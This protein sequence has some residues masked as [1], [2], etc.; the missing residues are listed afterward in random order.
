MESIRTLLESPLLALLV[1]VIGIIAGWVFYVRTLRDAN[2]CYQTRS[3][4][5]IGSDSVT[6]DITIS[7]KGVVVPHV[8]KS[9]LVFWNAGRGTL[10]GSEIVRDDP[11]RVQSN[12]QILDARVIKTTRDINAFKVQDV[13]SNTDVLACTLEF[14]DHRDGVT[15]SLFHTGTG[16]IKMLG[17]IQ[18]IRKGVRNKG[19]ISDISVT[20]LIKLIRVWFILFII[21]TLVVAYYIVTQGWHPS[22]LV[23]QGVMS[24][25]FVFV[26]MTIFVVRRVLA[27][28]TDAP[29]K[30][31]VLDGA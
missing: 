21:T 19:S 3:F 9:I 23:S 10:K 2:P 8:T 11:L 25:G 27:F 5:V 4:R 18:G 20:P 6:K 28:W 14:F 16:P 15:L 7:Y 26:V 29:S 22:I 1:G 13:G 12:G 17:T 30:L 31:L 24:V